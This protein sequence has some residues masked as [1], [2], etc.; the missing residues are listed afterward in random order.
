MPP[1][2]LCFFFLF[3]LLMVTAGKGLPLNIGLSEIKV[4]HSCL[5]ICVGGIQGWVCDDNLWYH[6]RRW[7]DD[8][9]WLCASDSG[10]NKETCF[11][12][13]KHRAAGKHLTHTIAL[14]STCT[15]GWSLFLSRQTIDY[16]DIYISTYPAI[17]RVSILTIHI[18]IVR[19]YLQFNNINR[20]Q[21]SATS[22]LKDQ[23][24][25]TWQE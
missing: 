8:A 4:L 16:I 20:P 2:W 23:A 10:D 6:Q 15:C 9:L 18:N 1:V 14:P 11:S 25:K 17:H 3:F 12:G 24:W 13:S 19:Y 5:S 22:P 7:G 21:C